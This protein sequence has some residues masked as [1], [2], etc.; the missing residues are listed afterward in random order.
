MEPGEVE[1]AIGTHPAV[2]EA[3]VAVRGEGAERRLVA[4]VVPAD[5]VRRLT[6]RSCGRTW[7]RSL[8]EYMVPAAWV[9]LEALP[10]TPSGKVDRRALPEPDAAAAAAARVPPRT[11]AEE[12]V[13]GIWERVLGVRPGAHDNFFDLGG[14]SLRATQVVSR[15]REAFGIDLPLRA[16][17][18]APT[19]AG[20]AARAVAA[21]AGGVRAARRRWCPSRATAT[22]RCRF[23]QQRFWFV[24][25]MGA[26]SNAYI[27]PMALRLRGRAG[28][29]RA[30]PRAGRRWW[31]GTSRCAPSSASRD[32]AAG[33][34]HPPRAARAPARATTCPRCRRR[35]AR[36]R[37]ARRTD[38]EVRDAR[39]T[40]RAGPLIRARLLRLAADDHLLLLSLHHIVARRVVAGRALPRAGGAVRGRA[41]RGAP[42][43]CRRSPCST[44]TTRS[45]SARGCSGEALERE[46][47]YWRGR[48]DGAPT[49]ALPTDRPHPAVQSFRGAHAGLRPGAR[50][51]RAA[52][53]E[54]A[55]QAAAPRR[56]WRC[57]PRSRPAAAALVGDGRRGR[58]QPHRRAHAARDG[59]ADRRLPQHAGAAHGPVAATPP[60]ASCWGGCARRRWTRSR[61][62]RCP[63]SGW[64]RSCGWSAAWRGTRSSR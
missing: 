56:S 5:G 33:A 14:H 60:S 19:V 29:G 36:R 64:W 32:G 7:P 11:P 18:E 48:L 9:V 46:L 31:S 62:R 41:R 3:A 28:R 57:W 4:Y 21:R 38:A 37:R 30:A 59:G 52:V 23:A 43:R 8:P 63:S 22:S 1:A 25:R 54:L 47:A 26:A 58:R 15:I 53:G 61:T 24:E 13:A 27:I 35:S 45:G 42:P 17:F 50:S 55:R 20:L 6:G 49:L 16:L 44:R 39:S 10:L 12:L 34:G 51:C 40:W 2:R